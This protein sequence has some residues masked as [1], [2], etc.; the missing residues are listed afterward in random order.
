MG[1]TQADMG[2]ML[3]VAA[4]TI[5]KWES[6]E[7]TPT[8]LNP[9]RCWLRRRIAQLEAVAANVDMRDRTEPPSFNLKAKRRQPI[10]IDG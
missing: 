10:E 2:K 5:R 8:R 6:R 1:I 3:G 9:F 4:I 7:R